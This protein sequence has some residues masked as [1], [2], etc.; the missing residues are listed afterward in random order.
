MRETER[1]DLG[2]WVLGILQ[3]LSFSPCY[4]SFISYGLSLSL[5]MYESVFSKFSNAENWWGGVGF[6]MHSQGEHMSI[7]VV[8]VPCKIKT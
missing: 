1:K 2:F 6:V 3:L 8:V 7:W 4:I 5:C